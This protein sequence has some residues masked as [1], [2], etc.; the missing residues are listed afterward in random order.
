MQRANLAVGKVKQ[1]YSD[2]VRDGLVLAASAKAGASLKRDAAVDLVVSRGPK[3]IPIKNY[4]NSPTASAKA[5]LTKAGFT[6]KITTAALRQD[7]QGSGGQAESGL[8]QGHEGRHRHPDLLTRTGAG[9][10]AERPRDGRTRRREGDGRRRF[11]DQGRSTPPVNYIGIGF[12]VYTDPQA[13]QQ[14][15]KGSTITLYVV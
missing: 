14:A 12:V 11:Q 4:V 1:K 15:P 13:R 9:D 10:R 6:V 3:P 2:S 5:A 8:R 7:R